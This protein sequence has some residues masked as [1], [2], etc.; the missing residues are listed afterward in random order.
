VADTLAQITNTMVFAVSPL[1]A[2]LNII[3]F[4]F[5]IVL[6][7]SGLLKGSVTF[8][9]VHAVRRAD[10]AHQVIEDALVF[11]IFAVL[12]FL[13]FSRASW[14]FGGALPTREY[15]HTVCQNDRS[16]WGGF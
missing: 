4:I 5:L 14:D 2:L 7:P 9:K 1:Y 3:H 8:S 6:S 15:L 16:N 12:L 10:L 11:L 13:S